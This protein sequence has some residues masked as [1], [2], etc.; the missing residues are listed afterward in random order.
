MPMTV[1]QGAIVL[2]AAPGGSAVADMLT[3]LPLVLASLLVVVIMAQRPGD[4]SPMLRSRPAER[5]LRRKN[6][7]TG[8]R[9]L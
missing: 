4:R 6:N 8:R 5:Q 3:I 2:G 9:P 1:L 7:E